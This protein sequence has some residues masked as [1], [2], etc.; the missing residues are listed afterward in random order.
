MSSKTLL[1]TLKAKSPIIL[2]TLGCIGV[3]AT[4]VAAVFDKERYDSIIEDVKAEK[5]ETKEEIKKTDVIKVVAKSYWR[6]AA[7]GIFSIC[8]I[9]ASN[10]ISASQ[11]TT[12]GAAYMASESKRKEFM[13]KAKE[14]LGEKKVEDIKN[15]I[16]DEKI[17]KTFDNQNVTIV[18]TGCG[19]QLFVDEWS[20]SV[21]TSDMESVRKG[22]NDANI[23]LRNTDELTYNEWREYISNGKLEAVD[24]GKTWGWTTATVDKVDVGFYPVKIMSGPYK[25]R[26]AMGI[27]FYDDSEPSCN[28]KY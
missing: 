15:S 2:L 8:C 7:I 5:E 26:V 14:Q 6:T 20:G 24:G 17:Q 4:A 27:R 1:T 25:D 10:R 16:S 18:N 13:D 28:I 9:I 12:M 11:L 22:W 23:E 3:A 19:E 21:F